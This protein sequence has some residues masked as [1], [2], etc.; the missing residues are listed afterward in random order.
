MT[1]SSNH[2]ISQNINALRRCDCV[3]GKKAT[4]WGNRGIRFLGG[5][6]IGQSVQNGIGLL[7]VLNGY[8]S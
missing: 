2:S 1:E 8:V 3:I 5:N 6:L 4:I 7:I